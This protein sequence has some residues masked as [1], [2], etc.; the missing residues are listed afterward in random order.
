MDTGAWWATYSPWGRKELEMTDMT[1]HTHI[2]FVKEYK[3]DG[4]TR[5][6]WRRYCKTYMR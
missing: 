2:H 5:Q 3:E 6:I 4:K 1:E